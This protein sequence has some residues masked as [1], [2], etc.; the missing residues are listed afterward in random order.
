MP[1]LTWDVRYA[2]RQLYKNPFFFSIVVLTLG[3][4]IGANTAI[5]SMVDW[6]VLRTLP[7]HNPQQMYFLVF[8]RPAGN[9]EV[10]F[11][12]PEFADIEK[13]T[14][15]VF[16]GMTP[17]IFGGLEGPQN[18]ANGLTVNG[19]TKPLQTVYVGSDFFSLLGVAPAAG[20]FFLANERENAGADPVVVLSY[21]YWQTRFNGDPSIMGGAAFINGHPVTIIGITPKGFL[22]P[23]PL[24]EAQAYL[25]LGMYSIERGVGAGFL[26]DPKARCMVAFVRLLPHAKT[27]QMQ[28]ELAVVG[29]R[30][31]M[32][33]PR[34]GTI[35]AL[36]ANPLRPPGLLSGSDVNPLPKLAALFLILAALVL[37]LACVNVA[38]LFLVRTFG[39]QREMAMRAALGAANTRLVRQLLTESLVV[40]AIGCGIGILLGVGASRVMSSVPM[41]VDLPFVLDFGFNWHAFLYAFLVAAA[42]AVLVMLVPIV[43][44]LRGNLQEILHEGGRGSTGAR[45]RLRAVLVASEVAACL[46]LLVISGLFVRSLRGVQNADLGF[47]PQLVLNLTLDSNE[48]GYTAEQGRA[49]YSA[50]LERTRALPGIE[51]A[52]LAS[53]VPLADNASGSDLVIPGFSANATQP[54]PHALY[55]VVSSDYFTTNGIVLLRGRDFTAADTESSA[56]VA[57]I[58]RAMADRYWPGQ[59][60]VGRSFATTADPKHPATIVGVVGNVRMNDIFGPFE[61]VYYRPITQSYEGA[62]TLQIRSARSPQELLPDVRNIVQS[63]SPALPIYGVRTMTEALHGGNGLLLFELAASLAASLGLLGLGLTLVGLY[64]LTS[65]AVSQRTQEIGIRMALGAQRHDILRVIGGQGF[66]VVVTG[67]AAGLMAAFTVGRL[68]GDFLVG[69]APTDPTTYVGV[70]AILAA[71]A[72]LATYVPVRRA[73]RV[74]PVVALRHE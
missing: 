50:L 14:T 28:S 74:D 39:R 7:I 68:V 43:R 17:F 12:Y 25:P 31:L 13:Q 45:Q 52:S 55:S 11:S 65:Y 15:D 34:Q 36:R 4:G 41:Q 32:D 66:L 19:V 48:I 5:F 62:A 47:H 53:S 22:G 6:L 8:S 24:V 35:G 30:L 29:Q 27:A 56:P 67:L 44:I 23:T 21:N 46:T 72:L 71:I 20:S 73:S 49:F 54:A 10:Q 70:S 16:S 40:A 9:N 57:V 59:D 37:A 42:S 58:N 33:Y 18:A 51:S 61:L 26:S 64:G 38:N 60:P 2:L 69:I 63:L 3:I 1:T